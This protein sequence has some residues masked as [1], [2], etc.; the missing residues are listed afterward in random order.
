MYVV[1]IYTTPSPIIALLCSCLMAASI[2]DGEIPAFLSAESHS[3]NS[4]VVDLTLIDGSDTNGLALVVLSA[5]LPASVEVGV[6][7]DLDEMAIAV[8][9]QT[10]Q[11]TAEL[12]Q[13]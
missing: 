11:A 4:S 9:V 3:S 12:R 13:G 6:I 8:G 10:S 5:H 2:I 7:K 1:A